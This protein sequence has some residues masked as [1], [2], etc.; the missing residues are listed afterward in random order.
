MGK[1]PCAVEPCD[2]V[3]TT[4]GLC[5][6][7]YQRWNRYGDVRPHDPIGGTPRPVRCTARAC[8]RPT[9]SR[10]LC[11]AHYRR[12]VRWGDIREDLPVGGIGGRPLGEP[13]ECSYGGCPSAPTSRG[14]C[15]KH[16]QRIRRLGVPDLPERVRK[17]TIDLANGYR[18]VYAPDH[19]NANTSGYVLEHRFV[20]SRV[21][22][23][24]LHEDESVHH[25]NGDRR[26][27]RPD[28][29]ELWSTSQPAGQRVEDKLRW[30]E[31]FLTRYGRIASEEA[32]QLKRSQDL[33]SLGNSPM[34]GELFRMIS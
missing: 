21:L 11:E 19:P 7:H 16:Y 9:A 20:M 1:K 25:L 17:Q 13:R 12:L 31:S 5:T 18:A 34:Q 4:R 22:G 27:N 33:V 10:G 23:R 15:H 6:A 28:N 30:A 26:D 8:E 32:V 2:R 29:L 3:A 14:W 24:A